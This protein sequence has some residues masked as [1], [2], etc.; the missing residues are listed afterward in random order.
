MAGLGRAI[1]ASQMIS[2]RG[3]LRPDRDTLF[4]IGRRPESS[5]VAF[6]AFAVRAV[7]AG[8][9]LPSPRRRPLPWSGSTIASRS[10]LRS[11]R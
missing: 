4:M 6:R 1:V 7:P 2:L 8:L 3:P 9:L 11:T 5:F 10:S